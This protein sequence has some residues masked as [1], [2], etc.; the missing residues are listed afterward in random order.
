MGSA[1]VESW[2]CHSLAMSL[3]TSFLSSLWFFALVMKRGLIYSAH[4][5][6][7]CSLCPVLFKLWGL[8]QGLR[9]TR[10]WPSVMEL[11]GCDD[12]MTYFTG[13]H[14]W[15]LAPAWHIQGPVGVSHYYFFF[16][17][18]LPHCLWP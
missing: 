15:W 4:I 12:H 11:T 13:Q 1:G 14:G 7:A 6:C 10:S 16:Y 18:Y 2:L 8:W 3:W 9:Q 17:F 5:Y